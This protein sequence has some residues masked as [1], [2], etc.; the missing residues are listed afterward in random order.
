MALFTLT[1][2]ANDA[3]GDSLFRALE[4][5]EQ[6][7]RIIETF[8]VVRKAV[9]VLTQSLDSFGIEGV[10]DGRIVSYD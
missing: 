3:C 5:L 8:L 1:I 7:A 2:A 9:I 6:L 10:V 4:K